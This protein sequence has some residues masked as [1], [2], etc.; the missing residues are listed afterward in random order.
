MG[1][2]RSCAAVL[3]DAARFCPRC[4]AAVTV[5]DQPAERKVATIV[6][7]DLVGSTA[8]GDQDPERSR[9][10]LAEFYELMRTEIQRFGGTVEKFIGDAVM[11]VFGAP[12]ALEDHPGRALRAALAMQRILPHLFNGALQLRIGV[13]TGQVVVGSAQAGSSFVT[14][15]PVNVAARLEQAARPGEV[16]VGERTAR[17][18]LDAF[19]FDPPRLVRAKGK[20]QGVKARR[21]LR[22]RVPAARTDRLLLGRRDE[23]Q[24]LD[25]AFREALSGGQAK[26]VTV[27]GE[28]GLGKTTL[29]D[30]WANGALDQ[31]AGATVRTGH[32]LAYG[33]GVTYAPLAEVLRQQLRIAEDESAEAVAA[34][35]GGQDILAL[36]LGLDVSGDLHPFAA[37]E[38]LHA[39]WVQL[40]REMTSVRPVVLW[41]EDVHWADDLL[42]E[43]LDRLVVDVSGPLLL[44]T[45]A[46]PEV[47]ERY[48]TWFTGMTRRDHTLI[49]LDALVTDDATHLLDRLTGSRLSE[50]IRR[51]VLERAEG[52]P[53]FLEE[54]VRSLLEPARP[55]SLNDTASPEIAKVISIPD[56]VQAVLAAR[57]D[58]LPEIAKRTLQAASVV[59]RT[60]WGGSVSQLLAP[61]IPELR[62][63]EDRGFIRAT[64]SSSLGME[65]EYT[66]SHALS[67][68]VAYESLS[69]SRRARL[70]ALVAEWM[71]SVGEGRDE[72]VPVMA[73]HW[74]EATDP[75]N[76]DLAWGD[77]P[78]RLEQLQLRAK[79][80]LKDAADAAVAQYSI[81]EAI[82][83]LERAL[84]L[85]P[86]Q[87]EQVDLL[88]SLGRVHALNY[89][90][91]AFWTT[92]HR[93]AELSD[94]AGVRA[95]L[96]AEMAFEV[97]ARWGMFTRMPS[98]DLVDGWI[99]Q[100]LDLAPATA[101]ARAR[102]LVAHC[103]WHPSGAE[104]LAAEAWGIAHRLND[105]E[106]RSHA[107]NAQAFAAFAAADFQTSRDWAGRRLDFIEGVSDPDLLADTYGGVIP[108]CLALGQFD[109]ARTFA[110]LHDD[111]AVRLSTHHQ[112]HAVAYLLELE[113][114]AENWPRIRKL[115][116]RAED[117]AKANLATP[118]VRNAR[119]LL[120]CALAEAELGDEAQAEALASTAQAMAMNG[121]EGTYAP[122]RIRLALLAGDAGAVGHWLPLAIAPPPAKNWWT[123]PTTAARLDA[124]AF[125]EERTQV[126][127]E[128]PQ[129]VIP[130]TYLQPFAL[131][132][133]GLARGDRRL[134]HDAAD[135]FGRLGLVGQSGATRTLLDTM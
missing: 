79:A 68:Q 80:A 14:G 120:V 82:Y 123:L 65:R 81:A 132:S 41:I 34:H 20:P 28:P 31:Q 100:A 98:A 21:L 64:G 47:M 5:E 91:E 61:S 6:F 8:W 83:W 131:R 49:W 11:A 38:R 78:A 135:E 97:S 10:M 50:G 107:A 9:V 27:L 46:R 19:E 76:A 87:A 127:A 33:R 30:R 86:T 70:H 124:M 55:E 126:E 69:K 134:L 89:D 16:L 71:E 108:S 116:A 112:V 32:C 40:V 115:R 110:D 122:L 3:P 92:M 99:T 44:V 18:T 42:F 23:L 60:F 118:C 24:A 51:Q 95:E 53:F 4:A 96:Y 77:D 125:L 74:A 72:H 12:D 117:A 109:D 25:L 130:G 26:H 15:D 67:Q 88:S 58:V 75:A 48:P 13:N 84:A 54:I 85:S 128:A 2:C 29:V 45:T 119:S 57:I 37:K 56:S 35:L 113:E 105:A 103:Y 17:S 111:V 93:A 129:Y 104:D 59:G 106:L 114:L 62:L 73:Y 52:N 43:L 90:G 133:L 7:A 63:L 94:D 36:T 101:P 22:E 39:A 66:F 1:T 102:A 121:A